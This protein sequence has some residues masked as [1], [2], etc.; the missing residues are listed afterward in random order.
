VFFRAPSEADLARLHQANEQRDQLDFE[1]V[2][3][4]TVKNGPKSGDLL[5]RHVRSYLDVFSSRQLLY[6][7]YSIQLLKAYQGAVKTN[8]GLL[9]STSLEFNAMLCGYKGWFKR[10][11]GAIRHV[12]A[13]HAY[14]F[15]YTVAENNP[16][17]REKSSGNLQLLF[18]DRIAQ[19]GHRASRA[20]NRSKRSN[21]AGPNSRRGRRWH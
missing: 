11:P 12:F 1:P 4:F 2:E 3:D 8:L 5:G 13:M 14:V 6:L 10:R 21:R 20:Q 17:N 7:Y 19:M 9:I 16:I 15:Q 18:R